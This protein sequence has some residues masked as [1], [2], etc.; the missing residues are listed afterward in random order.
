MTLRTTKIIL[1]ALSITVPSS[2]DFNIYSEAFR[3]ARRYRM[4]YQQAPLRYGIYFTP[5]LVP[6]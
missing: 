4:K 1:S 6:H 3:P 5:T 2:P